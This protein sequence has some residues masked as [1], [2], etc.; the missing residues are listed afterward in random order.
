[1]IRGLGRFQLADTLADW[2]TDG[3]YTRRGHRIAELDAELALA[4][5][6][7]I[8]RAATALERAAETLAAAVRDGAAT[9]K[10]LRAFHVLALDLLDVRAVA[11]GD[12]AWL[13]RRRA[14]RRRRQQ[15]HVAL[16]AQIKDVLR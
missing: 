6:S 14:E 4:H 12:E 7:D 2:C 1:M 15:A 10:Q 9:P 11:V 5:Q 3:D 16:S 8:A 13:R